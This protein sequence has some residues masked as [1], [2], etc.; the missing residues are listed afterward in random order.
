MDYEKVLFELQPIIKTSSIDSIPLEGDSQERYL[1][2]LDKVAICLRTEHNRTVAGSSGLLKRLLEVLEETLEKCFRTMHIDRFWWEFAS[3]LIRCVANCLVDSD[4]NRKILLEE[5]P[6]ILDRFAS[7]ILSM[8]SE[9]NE[10]LQLRTLAMTKNMCL[11]NKDYTRRFIKIEKPLLGL[12]HREYEEFL[13]LI[14]SEL[15]SD[16]IEVHEDVSLEDLQFFAESILSQSQEVKNQDDNQDDDNED[17]LDDPALEIL[18]NY[19][20]CLETVVSKESLLDFGDSLVTL[21]QIYLLQALDGLWPK[22]FENKLIYMRR[23]MSCVGH[24]SAQESNT[25]KDDRDICYEIIREDNNG[26]K[27]GAV[28][29]VLSNSIHSQD[30]AS[31]ISKDISVQELIEA[32]SKLTDPV[33][34]QGFLTVL[35]KLLT[36]SN[37]MELKAETIRKLAIILKRAHDQ[38]TFFKELSPLL[39]AFFNKIFTVLPSSTVY[40]S[41][42]DPESPLLGIVKDRD[43]II[44][45]LALNKLLI[46]SRAAP[47]AVTDPLWKTACKFQDQ[48]ASGQGNISIFYLFQLAK[49]FGILLKNL[50]SQHEPLANHFNPWIVQLLQFVKPL[51]DK[52]DQAS[53]SAVNNGRF[54]ATM[55]LKLHDQIDGA[56]QN[57]RLQILAKELF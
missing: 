44:S 9:N 31:E 2:V 55:V 17:A 48:V 57:E 45:C 6:V 36:I 13:V 16:F 7:H 3:D 14:G 34:M 35:R 22:Q 27:I 51:K 47:T 19:T 46:S 10:E 29:I 23:I 25:N 32:A 49:T 21:I 52:N 41:L 18:S 28:F 1:S 42:S 33:Q 38:T 11:D 53:Q 5:K 20:Q 4:D 54:V 12:L 24:I 39:N 8:N 40:D 26:Y 50:E 43:S 30:D 15:L 56:E 37:S